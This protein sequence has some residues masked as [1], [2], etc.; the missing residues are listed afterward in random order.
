MVDEFQD[1][2]PVQLRLLDLVAA[3]RL[4][5]VGDEF[6]S[7][8]GFRHADVQLFREL[9]AR[10]EAE[11]RAR[12]LARNY[13]GRA[14]LL[15]AINLAFAENLFGEGFVPLVP[16]DESPRDDEP[17]VEVLVCEKKGWEETD[18]G[19]GPARGHRLA[20]RG[21]PRGGRADARAARRRAPARGDRDPAA[22]EH[23]HG[24]IFAHALEDQG[25][26]T[27]VVGGRGYWSQR[28][29]Q[30]VVAYLAALA[31]PRD[32]LRIYEVL[33]SPMV[34]I[35]SDALTL[36][37]AAARR[38]GVPAALVVQRAVGSRLPTAGAQGM[39]FDADAARHRA[40]GRAGAGGGGPGR[41]A[42]P[43]RPRSPGGLRRALRAPPGGG[44][45]DGAGRAG[46]LRRARHRL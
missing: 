8:Y 37:G 14:E 10:R 44:A 46:G 34:G 2:N 32:D 35:S 29:V 22:R 40:G 42:S 24:G 39:L 12:V 45:P 16:A 41:R 27:Y 13:R 18:L 26:P 38:A 31:N 7:I 28:E 25:V 11:G 19:G 43:F 3:D 4:F 33:A 9:R 5:A 21:G 15:D 23:R 6:Q 1:T 30:D 17:P 36:V 20:A